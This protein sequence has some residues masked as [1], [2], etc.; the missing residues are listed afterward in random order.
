[1]KSL[2]LN[3]LTC[4]AKT[5]VFV[6]PLLSLV[7]QSVAVKA[8]DTLKSKGKV[9][10]A[11]IDGEANLDRLR[12]YKVPY[13]DSVRMQSV[14]FV[15]GLASKHATNVMLTVINKVVNKNVCVTNFPVFK[16]VD[17]DKKFLASE[18][19]SVAINKAVDSGYTV[20]N[21]SIG[22]KGR[23]DSERL[24]IL[25]GL[26]RGVTFVLASGNEGLVLNEDLCK[27]NEYVGC[28]ALINSW[29]KYVNNGQL[30]FVG[31]WNKFNGLGSNKVSGMVFEKPCTVMDSISMCGS[32][33]SAALFTNKLLKDL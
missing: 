13:C 11:V 22:G 7:C 16:D 23:M 15:E 19:I 32:S 20:I 9:K 27:D 30:I 6:I 25:R 28:Y 24:A 17:T 31:H 12:A 5:L 14:D 29:K 4:K 8:Q 1:M 21:L 26:V 33:Q 2:V 3:V 10:V 18:P